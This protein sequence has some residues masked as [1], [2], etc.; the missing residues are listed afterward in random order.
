MLVDEAVTD[1][2]LQRGTARFAELVAE[3]LIVSIRSTAPACFQALAADVHA[4][5]G[6]YLEAPVS[7]SRGAAEAGR[8]VALLGGDA[9]TV[10]VVP[11]AGPRPA[12]GHPR[13]PV[14]SGL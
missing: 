4:A 7:G 14:G 2:V 9:Q 3:H 6:R 12:P 13:R 11:P 8:L 1:R 10:A 5:G